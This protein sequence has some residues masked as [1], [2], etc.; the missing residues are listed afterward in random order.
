MT[1]KDYRYD[2]D[3]C[4]ISNLLGIPE[5]D[6][7]GETMEEIITKMIQNSESGIES[8]RAMMVREIITRYGETRIRPGERFQK[9]SQIYEHFRIRLGEAKQEAF[10]IVLLD[11][12]HKVITEKVISLGTLNQSLV[13]PREVFAPA[14]EARAAAIVLIHNHPS[15][16]PSP[17]NQ[18]I[19]I[20]KR[21]VEVG[22]VVGI[23]VIDHVIVGTDRYYSFVDED[24]M[25]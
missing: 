7:K 9:S 22:S 5:S 4:L 16:E 21:L 18:D 3:R 23:N 12:K 19:E 1:S 25:P 15:G 8:D 2:S 6:L 10:Y 20:T 17:S 24:M 14:I 11:N 13:H